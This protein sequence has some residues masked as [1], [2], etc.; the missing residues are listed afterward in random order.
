MLVV[1]P[2]GLV[3]D[4]ADGLTIHVADQKD[5]LNF[6]LGFELVEGVIFIV[7][8]LPDLESFFCQDFF[9]VLEL[10]YYLNCYFVLWSEN[11]ESK[12]LSPNRDH[13]VWFLDHFGM[14]NLVLASSILLIDNYFYHWLEAIGIKKL[15]I[16]LSINYVESESGALH[17]RNSI[18]P[19]PGI[20]LF[21]LSKLKL[22]FRDF[23]VHALYIFCQK[24]NVVFT[25][26]EGFKLQIYKFLDIDVA[27]LVCIH[28]QKY[29]I[30]HVFVY[31]LTRELGFLYHEVFE[32]ILAQVSIFVHIILIKGF[33]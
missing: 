1:D 22:N 21:E 31:F 33:F 11:V 2:S 24:F 26:F 15:I 7:T 5:I 19:E 16:K 27:V 3:L 8:Y 25:I 30:E 32:F 10:I 13:A 17:D 29:L 4:L 18:N 28:L 6:T 20:S 12:Y 23:Q 9:L 14:L